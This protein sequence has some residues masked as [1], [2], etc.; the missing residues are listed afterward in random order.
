MKRFRLLA[1]ALCAVMITGLSSGIAVAGDEDIYAFDPDKTYTLEWCINELN[2]PVDED[3][4]I[5]LLLEE[6]YNVKFNVWYADR[7]NREE[8]LNIRFASG[9][10]PDIMTTNNAVATA[11]YAGQGLLAE[12]PISVIEDKMP[13][14]AAANEEIGE[15]EGMSPYVV[16]TIDGVNYGLPFLNYNGRFQYSSLWRKDWLDAVGIDKIPETIEE[17]DA[18]FYAIRDGKDKLIEAGLTDQSAENIYG[19]SS[20]RIKEPFASIYGAYGYFPA[21]WALRDG[22]MVYGAVQPEMKDALAQMATWYADGILNPEF[23]TGENRGDHWSISHDFIEGRIAYTNNGPFYQNMPAGHSVLTP[24]GGRMY[25]AFAAVNDPEAMV[26][27]RPP[28][29]PNGDSGSIVWGQTTGGAIV[30]SKK[31]EQEPDKFGKIMEILETLTTNYDGYVLVNYGIEDVT[32]VWED[33]V[34]KNIVPEEEP[35]EKYGLNGV[36]NAW[37]E[38]LGFAVQDDPEYY[39]YGEAV[40]HFTDDYA[41]ALHGIKLPSYDIYWD[42]LDKM[43]KQTYIDI[44]TGKSDIDAFDAFVENWMKQGGEV[45]TQEANDWYQSTFAR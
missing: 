36:F 45:I 35:E 18:A 41:D 24:N 11:N 3:A 13:I 43:Q 28:I 27:G 32:W 14:I 40:A 38:A 15:I 7:S 1:L 17:M 23:I 26:D 19:L 22:E 30:F 5:K 21:Y 16:T 9:E 29:G 37:P 8:L 10:F 6:R 12:L 2:A 39:E 44:I 4:P 42:E 20:G 34:R 33:G 25:K 31:L